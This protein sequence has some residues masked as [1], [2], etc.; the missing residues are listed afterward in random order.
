MWMSPTMETH[1]EKSL[2]AEP[3]QYSQLNDW[4]ISLLK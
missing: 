4:T 3:F 1:K 2:T